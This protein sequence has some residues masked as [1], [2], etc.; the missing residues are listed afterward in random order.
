[1]TY[2]EIE[3]IAKKQLEEGAGY[4]LPYYKKH[5]IAMMCNTVMMAE[6]KSR[7]IVEDMIRGMC[8]IFTF[9]ENNQ[10]EKEL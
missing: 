7:L 2:K 3:E 10:V 6:P 1:M 5:V 4:V 8:H 9:G